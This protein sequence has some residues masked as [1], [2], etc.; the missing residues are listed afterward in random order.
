MTCIDKLHRRMLR[1][2]LP[3]VWLLWLG[4]PLENAGLILEGTY[5]QFRKWNAGENGTLEMEFKTRSPS[6]LLMYTDDGG[7]YDFFELKMV[8]GILRLRYNLGGGAQI[9]VAGHDLFDD[10]WHRVAV[11]RRGAVTSLTVDNTTSSAT[12]TG[13]EMQFGRLVSNSDVYVGGM[14]GWYNGRLTR[15][16]LPSVIF[17]PRFSGTVRNIIYADD[18]HPYPRRQTAIADFVLQ[19]ECSG[20]RCRRTATSGKKTKVSGGNRGPASHRRGNPDA[21]EKHDPCQH[22][23]ICISTDFG[24]KCECRDRNYEGT[25]C[26]IEKVIAEASF[27]GEEFLKYDFDGNTEGDSLTLHFKTKQPAGLLYHMGD[28]GNNYLNVGVVTGGISVTMKVG[29]GTLDMFIKPNRIRF[30]DNQWHKILVTRKIQGISAVTS[31]CKLSVTVDDVYGEQGSSAGAFTFLTLG[32]LYLGGSENTPSLAG[33]KASTN[34]IGCIKKVEYSSDGVRK[35][36]F[37]EMGKTGSSSIRVVGRLQYSCQDFGMNDPVCLSTPRSF[38]MLPN[39]EGTTS[40]SISVKFRT[41]EPDGLLFF[42]RG[43]T[44][45]TAGAYAV[46]IVD[47]RVYVYLDLGTGGTR[48]EISPDNAKINDGEWHEFSIWRNDRDIHCTIDDYPSDFMTIGDS[49]QLHLQNGIMLGFGGRA[50]YHK[51]VPPGVWTLSMETGFVGCVRDLVVDGVTIN[52]V[53]LSLEQDRVSVTSHCPEPSEFIG[54]Q[55]DTCYNGGICRQGWNRVI[56]DCWPTEYDGVACTR[57]TPAYNFNGSQYVQAVMPDKMTTQAEDMYFRFKTNRPLAMLMKTFDSSWDRLEIALIVGKIR[58]A[59]KIGDKE[60]VVLCGTHLDDNNWHYLHYARRGHEIRLKVD[61]ETARDDS[62]LDDAITLR[63][64][65]MLIGGSPPTD[66]EAMTDLPSFIGSMR[67][68]VVNKMHFF[69]IAKIAVKGFSEDLPKIHMTVGLLKQEKPP[70]MIHTVTFLSKNTFVGLPPLKAYSRIEVY[71]RF[72]TRHSSGLFFFNG[73][74][75]K[76]NDFALTE[77]VNGHVLVNIRSGT[78]VV[79]LRDTSKMVLN[80]NF[81]HTIHLVQISPTMFC[82]MVDDQV[83]A[84][85]TMSRPHNIQLNDMFYVGGVPKELHKRQ[86]KH[87]HSRHGFEGC[88]SGLEYNGESPDMVEN[89]VIPSTLVTA[90]CDGLGRM[91][92]RDMCDNH[93]TCVEQWNSYSCDCDMTAYV[94]LTCSEPSLSYEFGPD[95]GMMSYSFPVGQQ[96]DMQ[97]DKLAFGIITSKLNGVMFRVDSGTSSDYLQ[98]EMI[99]GN[100]IVVYNIGTNDHPI[101]EA[102]VKVNDNMYHLVR[103]TRSG[104]NSTLQVDDNSMQTHYPSGHQL[105]VFN[106]QSTIQV[107]GRWNRTAQRIENGYE[108]VMMGLVFNGLRVFDLMAD[109][110]SRATSRGD[111]HVI[112]SIIDRLNEHSLLDTMQ[113]TPASGVMDD[114]VYSGAGSG[115]NHDDED[116]CTVA[117]DT[118]GTGDDLITPVYV[119]ATA[120][121]PPPLA[122]GVPRPPTAVGCDDDDEETD[123]ITAGSGFGPTSPPGATEFTTVKSSKHAVQVTTSILVNRTTQ[124]APNRTEQHPINTTSSASVT[125]PYSGRTSPAPP[126][127]SSYKPPV[128]TTKSTSSVSTVTS[129]DAASVSS[130]SSSISSTTTSTTTVSTISP[131]YNTVPDESVYHNN[132]DKP[133]WTSQPADFGDRFAGNPHPT[134]PG[135]PKRDV[136]IN[137]EAAEST[138][139]VVLVTTGTLIVIVLIILVVLKVKYRTDTNRYKIEIPKAYPV[140][141]PHHHQQQQQPHGRHQ[142]GDLHH[143]GSSHHHNSNPLLSPGGNYYSPSS[144]QPSPT[145]SVTYVQNNFRTTRPANKKRQDV[146]E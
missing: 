105:N 100:I 91:C 99:N 106:G 94:G 84:T 141:D 6:G 143:S 61:N 34:F 66:P 41:N 42:S 92:A 19:P 54:C 49:N 17:E 67:Q 140:V 78:H 87:M 59:L 79:R 13:K 126:P 119:P 30:D 25:Y 129:T 68:F 15:L 29:T 115:C 88:M 145:A 27:T 112:S 103:F 101:G 3:V 113:Q 86:A 56:C 4:A 114:L 90:G 55:P 121:P 23:G 14:P 26:E 52:L 64:Q 136:P 44:E 46:E 131:Y 53:G 72:K 117:Y 98:V 123:C 81:W 124:S 76:R 144:M 93:G 96:P 116:Q 77:L 134:E 138:A 125:V 32:Y 95:G 24:P 142:L 139:Y 65:G 127:F 130:S 43:Q 73:A 20:S 48:F 57:D 82:L 63:W 22:G 135:T 18:S 58:L 118:T 35:Y 71:F 80:D 70:T 132:V 37:L 9:L 107:G 12:S 47:G 33:T 128:K 120:V 110:D 11:E 8:E 28:G 16:A 75:D 102:N 36:D 111:C 60:K 146:K 40:G 1:W 2:W 69:D 39:W 31:F 108:G 62:P 89:A 109:G 21:C 74:G 5:G 50:V 122:T 51:K 10:R 137:T 85:T 104:P 133:V 45:H 38:L 83:V 97:N 7:T